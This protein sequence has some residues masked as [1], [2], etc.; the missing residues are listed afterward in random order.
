[1]ADDQFVSPGEA[2][3]LL[4]EFLPGGGRRRVVWI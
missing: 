4:E 2:D 3:Y 1:M